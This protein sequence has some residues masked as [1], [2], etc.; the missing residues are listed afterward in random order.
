MPAIFLHAAYD[1]ICEAVDSRLAEPMRAHCSDLTEV[2]VPSGHWM[3]QEKP[4]LV[5][6]AL[7]KWMAA[8]GAGA[9][10]FSLR[11]NGHN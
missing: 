11:V 3:A 2:I 6:S 8:F 4:I 9:E 5:N 10:K 7:T 1:Y